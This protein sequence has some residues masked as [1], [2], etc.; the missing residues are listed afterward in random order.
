MVRE[1][2]E[3]GEEIEPVEIEG[4]SIARSFWGKAWCEHLESFGDYS[5]RLPRGR[6]YV[7]HG[8]VCHLDIDKGRVDAMVAGSE[9]YNVEIDISTLDKKKWAVIKHSCTGKIGSLIELLQGKL[10]DEIMTIVTDRQEGLFPL[11]GEIKYSCDCPDWARMCKHIAAVIYGIGARLDSRPELLF[12]LRGVDHQEL[13]SSESVAEE[14]TG[15]RS[16]RSNRRTL[17][18]QDV[19]NVFGVE[20]EE[21]AEE[22][23]GRTASGRKKSVGRGKQA[24]AASPKKKGVRTGKDPFMPTAK[25]IA[26]LRRKLGMSRPEFASAIGVSAATVRNW[27]KSYGELKLHAKSRKGLENIAR[28]AGL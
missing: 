23:P 11:P 17:S 15:R 24:V 25:S 4:R 7:R 26:G 1:L 12:L 13:V 21:G 28:R 16:R 2:R 18:S 22:V 19:E 3:N 9:M 14:I 27:E 8:S 5:N 6:K 20:L 10:S